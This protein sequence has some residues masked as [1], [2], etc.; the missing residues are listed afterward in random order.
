MAWLTRAQAAAMNEEQRLD[1]LTRTVLGE[2]VGEGYVGMVVVGQVIANRARDAR[3]PADPVAVAGQSWQFTTNSPGQGGNQ[4]MVGRNYGPN[5]REYQM[6]RAA[7]EATVINRTAPDITGGAVQYHTIAMGWPAS[8][9]TSIQ[10]H[11]HIDIG[12]HRVYPTHPVPP[13]DIP[14]AIAQLEYD[15]VAVGTMLDVRSQGLAPIR[16]ATLSSALT[17]QRE[18]TR[19]ANARANAP[20]TIRRARTFAFGSTIDPFDTGRPSNTDPIINR[21][22]PAMRES[23]QRQ[24]R[25]TGTPN[26]TERTFALQSAQSFDGGGP[27]MVSN[28][29]LSRPPAVVAAPWGV[30]ET[31]AAQ[32]AA[33]AADNGRNQMVMSG[34]PNIAGSVV[35]WLYPR[36]EEGTGEANQ[37]GKGDRATG[38]SFIERGEPVKAKPGQSII[39]RDPPIVRVQPNGQVRV[40][41]QSQIERP[42][43]VTQSVRRANEASDPALATTLENQIATKRTA[44]DVRTIREANQAAAPATR[45]AVTAETTRT[46]ADTRLL[47]DANANAMPVV[48]GPNAAPKKQERLQTVAGLEYVDPPRN[49]PRLLPPIA[50]PRSNPIGIMPNFKELAQIPS[51]PLRPVVQAPKPAD[52]AARERAR[53]NPLFGTPQAPATTAEVIPLPVNRPTTRPAALAPTPADVETRTTARNRMQAP[54]PA[55]A[56]DRDLARSRPTTAGPTTRT[57]PATRVTTTAPQPASP[58]ARDAARAKAAAP[59][60]TTAPAAAPAASPSPSSSSSGSGG[61]Q[62]PTTYVRA[63]TGESLSPVTVR[64]Y[65]P[66]TNSFSS[67]TVYR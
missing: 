50:P 38:R 49:P 60:R 34:N 46:A 51:D 56:A 30:R 65:D 53:G 36:I 5:T 21:P 14:G 35:D 13:A 45:N 24:L 57:V 4:D 52:T 39:E 66:D 59:A 33:A 2:A 15:S 9:P 23:M 19:V 41:P 63:S 58:A 47:R 3:F 29:L 55:S 6:A 17:L 10:Q 54:N 40:V 12:N 20:D 25:A 18:T 8:W 1:Y 61:S 64:S 62:A 22:E 28:A 26:M 37:E 7:V 44:A 31:V 67:K 27:I 16:P 48:P 32:V 42:D 43:V 11:G